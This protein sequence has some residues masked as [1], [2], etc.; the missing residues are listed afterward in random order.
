MVATIGT[1][2]PNLEVST[3]VQGKPTNIEEERGNVV[4]VEVFQVN[5][6]GCFLYSMPEAI[7]IYRKYGDKGLTVLGLATAFEDFDKNNLDNL[8][9]L[10]S[11]GEVI[12]ETY[13]AFSNTGQ[14][15]DDNKLPYKIPFPIAMDM[16]VKHSGPLI[17]SKV[18][19]FIEANIPSFRSYTEK[20]RQVLIERVKQYLK[21]KEY[22]AMTFEQYTLRGTPS[23]ILVDRKGVLRGTYFGSDGFLEGAVEELIQ[24]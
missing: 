13:R 12:G 6:P 24:E 15:R 20:D 4:L 22:S 14:L 2:A 7:D 9:K 21:S 19:D 3:W 16:L 5:C 23:A 11:T 8:Q 18:M 17:D 1:K 10:V